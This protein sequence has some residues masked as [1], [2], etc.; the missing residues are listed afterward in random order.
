MATSLA[1][2]IAALS[3]RIK[4]ALVA[5]GDEPYVAE[6]IVMRLVAA[7]ISER[8]PITIPQYGEQVGPPTLFRRSIFPELL[9]LEGDVGG[10]QLLT[11]YPDMVC[12]VPFR[13]EDRP[14]DVDTPEDYRALL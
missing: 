6:H 8:M 10:R 7:H 4:V 9:T 12:L 14:R 2:G 3:G 5:L 11:K 1:A 13:Q